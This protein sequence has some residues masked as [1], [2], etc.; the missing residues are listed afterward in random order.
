[1]DMFFVY[2]LKCGLVLTVFYTVHA[3]LLRRETFHRFNRVIIMLCLGASLLLPLLNFGFLSD[4]SL[5]EAGSMVERQ[6]IAPTVSYETVATHDVKSFSIATMLSWIYCLGLLVYVAFYA[7]KLWDVLRL[8]RSGR[9][10]EGESSKEVRVVINNRVK[11]PFSWFGFIV[12]NEN[13]LRENGHVLL[14]HEKDHVRLRHS[15]DLLLCDIVV[16]LQWFNPFAWLLRQDLSN[17]HEYQV[18]ESLLDAGVDID[19]YSRLLIKKAVGGRLIAV[20]NGLSASALKNRFRMMYRQRS[21]RLRKVKAVCLVPLL[22]G[23]V[24]VFA[25]GEDFSEMLL[26]DKVGYDSMPVDTCF[27]GSEDESVKLSPVSQYNEGTTFVRISS[28]N[29]LSS[30]KFFID[31]KEVSKSEMMKYGYFRE[32]KGKK[33]SFLEFVATSKEV[34]SVSACDNPKMNKDIYGISDPCIEIKLAKNTLKKICH[35]AVFIFSRYLF[36]FDKN[37]C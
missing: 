11:S 29:K 12:M 15:W 5:S 1:M 34:V 36:S 22:L 4:N 16:A 19:E 3:L 8:I 13:D 28:N 25:R 17:L 35:E 33:D 9:I 14:A 10:D 37:L 6:I 21:K 27:V 18:D 24:C 23:L 2:V 7:V 32:H 30:V 31:K 26:W 20:V